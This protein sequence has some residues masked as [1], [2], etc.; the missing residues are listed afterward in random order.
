MYFDVLVEG[1]SSPSTLSKFSLSSYF[2]VATHAIKQQVIL[3][4]G[5]PRCKQEPPINSLAS[6][7]CHVFPEKT[8]CTFKNPYEKR[9]KAQQNK[10]NKQTKHVLLECNHLA[11][12]MGKYDFAGKTFGPHPLPVMYCDRSHDPS[13]PYLDMS[14]ISNGGYISSGECCNVVFGTRGLLLFV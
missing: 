4:N 1:S 9:K 7:S 14:N 13:S 6:N 12:E 3:K 11:L 8:F 5:S 10:A 2:A